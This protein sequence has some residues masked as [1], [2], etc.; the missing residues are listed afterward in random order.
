MATWDEFAGG[1]AELAGF[2]EERLKS[3][4]AYL[5]TVREDG[6]PRVHPV[7][8]IIGHGRLFLFMEPASPKGRDLRRDGRYSLH[9]TVADSSGGAGEFYLRGSAVPVDDSE[10]R[11]LATDAA[12]YAPADRYVLFEL[13]IDGA[14]STV[15]REGRPDRRRWGAW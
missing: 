5:A 12:S 4:V 13:G 8:P 15:Y 9:C 7:T 11:R 2:G 10:T 14:A 3:G 1:A 6:S